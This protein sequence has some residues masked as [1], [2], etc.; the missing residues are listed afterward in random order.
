[1]NFLTFILVIVFSTAVVTFVVAAF[2]RSNGLCVI[3]SAVIAES[4]LIL[5]LL[6]QTKDSSYPED[7]LLGVNITL[8]EG[9]PVFVVSAIGFT[10]L[11]RRV[12]RKEK[13]EA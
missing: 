13:K 6:V 1:V 12:Y 4:L 11:A 5:F 8:L 10:F 9:T 2:V 3:S 7:V